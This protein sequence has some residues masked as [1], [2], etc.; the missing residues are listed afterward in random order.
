MKSEKTK[1]RYRRKHLAQQCNSYSMD[2][3]TSVDA[4]PRDIAARVSQTFGERC[5]NRVA[6]DHHDRNTR[7]QLF[8]DGCARA[9]DKNDIRVAPNDFRREGFGAGRVLLS[10]IIFDRKVLSLD[11]PN[12]R[13]SAKKAREYLFSLCSC[14]SALRY[15]GTNKAR[16]FLLELCCAVAASGY[17]T[18]PHRTPRKPAASSP[19]PSSGKA[20]Y[21]LK[22]ALWRPKVVRRG[23]SGISRV[24]FAVGR[25][26]TT[27]QERNT[28]S[29]LSEE[30]V[31]GTRLLISGTG[32]HSRVLLWHGGCCHAFVLPADHNL[33]S[34]V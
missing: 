27:N 1:F 18:A 13:S 17:A 7:R 20:S 2:R 16:C 15:D 29:P 21:W 4:D 10:A 30:N 3:W 25:S 19:L 9:S 23:P 11:L 8:E 24:I 22:Q 28:S 32:S 12:R 33:R 5:L 31:P 26:H 34:D 6:C 14:Q